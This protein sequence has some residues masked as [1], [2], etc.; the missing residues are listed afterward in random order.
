MHLI[1]SATRDL[2]HNPPTAA[3]AAIA[4]AP[5]PDPMVRGNHAGAHDACFVGPLFKEKCVV[6]PAEGWEW[7]NEAKGPRPKWGYVATEPGRVLRL[8]L[9][10]TASAGMRDRPV[11]VQIAHLRSYKHMGWAEVTC[12]RGCE[13]APTRFNGHAPDRKSLLVLHRLYASQSPDC[14][15]AV[16]VLGDTDSGEHKVKVAGAIVSD[17]AG[18]QEGLQNAG[19]VEHVHDIIFRQGAGHGAS[20]GGVFDV[21]NHI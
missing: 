17:Q 5:L 21:R 6:G 2:R 16:E 15:L 20:S 11:L 3:D 12:E 4:A 1:A 9:N 18:E 13:C 10:T 14:R 7:V 8:K 19:A